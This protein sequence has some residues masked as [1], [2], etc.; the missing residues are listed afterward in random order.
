M[1]KLSEIK[2]KKSSQEKKNLKCGTLQITPIECNMHD[3]DR[4]EIQTVSKIKT[5]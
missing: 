3:V 1:K 2:T 4:A 5:K